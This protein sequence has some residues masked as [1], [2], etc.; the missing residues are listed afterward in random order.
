[1]EIVDPTRHDTIDLSYGHEY[2]QLIFNKSLLWNNKQQDWI[3]AFYKRPRDRV[4]WAMYDNKQ[5]LKRLAHLGG[6][7]HELYCQGWETVYQGKGCASL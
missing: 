2:K 7:Y 6:A 4:F 3:A 1:M 5:I